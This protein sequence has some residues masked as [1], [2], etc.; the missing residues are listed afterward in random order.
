MP[1]LLTSTEQVDLARYLDVRSLTESLTA[2]LSA[3]DQ[4][5]QSIPDTSP[6]K[7]HRAHTSWFFETFLLRPSLGGYTPFHPAFSYLFNSYYEGVGSLYPRCDRGLLSRPGIDEVAAYRRHVDEAM[8]QLVRSSLDAASCELIELG[9]HHEQQHQELLLMDIKHVLSR[10]PLHPSYAS[11]STP[12]ADDGIIA[13]LGWIDHPGGTVEIGF[14]GPGF[15]YDNERPR[16]VVYLPSF[17]LADR[18]VTCGQWSEFIDDGGYARADL[19]LAD[20]WATVQS[21]QWCAPL[22]WNRSDDEWQVFTLGGSR[23][24]RSNE[25]VC[26]ISYYEADAFARWADARL[27]TEA[28]WEVVATELG[29][30]GNFLDQDVL[31]PLPLRADNG[32]A[33]TSGLGGDVWQWTSSAYGPFPGFTVA[34]G[35]VGEYNGKFMVNQYV[36]RGGSCATPV[37]HARSTY[38]N[39]FP[40]SARW[41]F[42]GLRL[43]RDT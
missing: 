4:T 42:S 22:Y 32:S 31:H 23:A 30:G 11:L 17:A 5:V 39:F 9:L 18:P 36:L 27:P 14:E 20:G 40:P 15:S 16:H 38:R 1:E 6:T 12:R 24:V 13:P 25:P 7:W 10:N 33:T 37:G 43:A 3:E 34:P 35:A 26:H 2:P 21:E 8:E 29:C 28:E 41:A 19:W